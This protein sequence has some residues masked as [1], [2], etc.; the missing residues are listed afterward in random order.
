MVLMHLYSI[1]SVY[2]VTVDRYGLQ[3]LLKRNENLKVLPSLASF[4][5]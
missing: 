5:I 2:T 1:C 3:V 4:K